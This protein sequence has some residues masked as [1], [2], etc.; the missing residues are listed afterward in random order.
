MKPKLVPTAKFK[1]DLKRLQKRGLDLDELYFVINKLLNCET[2]DPKHR[3]HA[4]TGNYAG[5][6]ECHIRPDWLFIYAICEDKLILTAA[7]CGSHSDLFNE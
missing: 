2:L 1:K 4:L 7:R 3:D 6:R 5:F